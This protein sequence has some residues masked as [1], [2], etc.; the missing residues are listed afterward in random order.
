MTAEIGSLQALVQKEQTSRTTAENLLNTANSKAQKLSQELVHL[1]QTQA[2]PPVSEDQEFEVARLREEISD[3][4]EQVQRYR[5]ERDSANGRVNDLQR[6]CA[7]LE[8][9]K[10]DTP[11]ELTFQSQ[12]EKDVARQEAEREKPASGQNWSEARLQKR[13]SDALGEIDTLKKVVRCALAA[14]FY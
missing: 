12:R 11:K 14:T 2:T 13:L 6:K 8:R 4:Q 5:H 9:E 10:A 1:E 3:L 7:E